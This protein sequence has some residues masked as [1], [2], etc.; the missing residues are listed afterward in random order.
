M[1]RVILKLIRKLV[2]PSRIAKTAFEIME[3]IVRI[4]FVLVKVVIVKFLD[5]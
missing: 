1:F 2:Q 5:Y 4:W 3:G